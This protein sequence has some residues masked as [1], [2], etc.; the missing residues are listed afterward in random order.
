M[1]VPDPSFMLGVKLNAA[2]FSK[3]KFIG[4]KD[5]QKLAVMLDNFGIDFIELSGGTYEECPWLEDKVLSVHYYSLLVF[6][7][8]KQNPLL[9][10]HL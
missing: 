2:D 1:A 8:A 7:S 5:I 9:S 4:E 10:P 3:G 6:M